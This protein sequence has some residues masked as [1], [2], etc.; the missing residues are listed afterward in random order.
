MRHIILSILSELQGLAVECCISQLLKQSQAE[1]AE[2]DHHEQIAP[3]WQQKWDEL[4]VDCLAPELNVTVRMLVTHWFLTA[5]I[6][7]LRTG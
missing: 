5:T 1:E 2:T 7:M 6:V 3:F 4:C